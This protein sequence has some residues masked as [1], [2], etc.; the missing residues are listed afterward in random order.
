M[1]ALSQSYFAVGLLLLWRNVD[2]FRFLNKIPITEQPNLSAVGL[3]V[4]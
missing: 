3:H 2:N 4:T 1:L